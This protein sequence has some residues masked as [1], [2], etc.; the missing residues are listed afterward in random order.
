MKKIGTLTRYLYHC[1][2]KNFYRINA[3]N[4]NFEKKMKKNYLRISDGINTP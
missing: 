4:N 3:P 1:Q 2:F